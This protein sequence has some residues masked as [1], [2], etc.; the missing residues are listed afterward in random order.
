METCTICGKQ[1][2]GF[3][4]E[5]ED[6]DG[7]IRETYVCKSCSEVIASIAFKVVSSE[8]KSLADELE[9]LVE[10]IT[11]LKKLDDETGKFR[12]HM[13]K[14][15][16]VT[17]E[18]EDLLSKNE[19]LLEDD[20][21]D[22]EFSN[23]EK[24]LLEIPNDTLA[25][26]LLLF[27]K[28]MDL[29][30]EDTDLLDS[31]ILE[32][33]WKSK[34]IRNQFGA[35]PESKIKMKQV[36]KRARAKIIEKIFTVSDE[37]LAKELADFA[38]KKEG[39]ENG[40]GVY[41]QASAFSFWRSKGLDYRAESLEIEVRKGQIERLAQEIID[42]EFR[43]WRDKRLQTETQYLPQLV[44]ACVEWARSTGRSSVTIKDIKYFR[45][46]KKIEL[47]EATER[48]LYLSTNNELKAK[49]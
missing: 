32:L 29:A 30:D 39:R 19:E 10:F 18:I 49:K 43:E 21:D 27:A 11:D 14:I 7:Q 13:S 35:S 15:E 8:I 33:F 5:L 34:G 25:E 47:L 38:K 2:E 42:R 28:E 1:K 40:Q 22:S 9:P 45:Q 16:E 48:A 20:D 37:D 24:Q 6:D 31:D 17:S 4:L 23:N 36:E 26:Q 12:E 44:Q 3:T 46:E 41:V